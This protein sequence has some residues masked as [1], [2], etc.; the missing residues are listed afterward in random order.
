[1]EL[2]HWS[3]ISKSIRFKINIFDGKFEDVDVSMEDSRP[4]TMK[5]GGSFK[6]GH[7]V[8]G[9]VQKHCLLKQIAAAHADDPAFTQFQNKFSQFIQANFSEFSD[10][11][12]DMI[13]GPSAM[14]CIQTLI[15]CSNSKYN[16]YRDT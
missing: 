8:L 12:M 14:V 7:I 9:A 6:S 15:T 5:P 2:D 4:D 11:D 3:Q 13:L 10:E 16:I 1:M